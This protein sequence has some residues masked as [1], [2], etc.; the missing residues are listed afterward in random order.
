MPLSP[1]RVLPAAVPACHAPTGL[2]RSGERRF[3][4]PLLQSP[5]STHVATQ[6]TKEKTADTQ[7]IVRFKLKDNC[8]KSMDNA[9]LI[10]LKSDFISN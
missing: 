3:L 5:R 10:T 2:W 1:S 9:R 6:D 7:Q 8:E 4:I